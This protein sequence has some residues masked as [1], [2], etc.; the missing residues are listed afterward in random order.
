MD[1]RGMRLFIA[2]DG[3]IKEPVKLSWLVPPARAMPQASA[4]HDPPGKR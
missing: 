3:A 4:P 2:D 1:M